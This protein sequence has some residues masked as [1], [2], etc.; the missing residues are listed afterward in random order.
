MFGHDNNDQDNQTNQIHTSD[1]PQTNQSVGAQPTDDN[2]QHPSTLL[3]D[4][5]N[6]PADDQAQV[7]DT[8]PEQ[9]QPEEPQIPEPAGP[10]EPAPQEESPTPEDEPAEN[11]TSNDEDGTDT[12]SQA[13]TSEASDDLIDLKQE[14]LTKLSPLVDHLDQSPEEKFRTLMMMIQASD[15]QDL[16]RQAYETA[17]EIEDEKERAQ[18]LLDVVNEINYFTQNPKS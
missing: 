18:A 4:N 7:A 14:A 16:V 8:Q 13:T 15:N 17:L 9:A 5:G 1:N 2:W 12:P 3:D 6:P 10:A 11:Y